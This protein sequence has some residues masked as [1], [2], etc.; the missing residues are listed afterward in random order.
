MSLDPALRNEL[1]KAVLRARGEAEDAA[2]AALGIL[3]VNSP[4]AFATLTK[5]QRVLRNALRAKSRQVGGFSMLVEEV[6]YAQWHRM[7]FARFLAE[8]NLLMHPEKHVAVTLDECEDLAAVE[9]DPDRWATAARYAGKMLPGIFSPDDPTVEVSFAPEGRAA[10]DAILAALPRPVFTSDDG[11]GWVYQFWQSKKKKEVSGSGRKIEKLDLAAYSQLFTEDYMVRFLLENSLGAWWAARHPD[12]KLL[13]DFKYLRSRDDGTPAAGTFPGWPERAADVTVMDPC[14]GSG[15]FLVAAFDMLR[16]MRMEEEGIGEAEAAAAVLRDNL[17]GLEIDPR[18]VQI[19]AFALALAAWKAGGYGD[20]PL[21]NVACSGIAARGQLEAWTRLARDDA[22]MRQALE[23]LHGMF[24]NAPDLGS[25]IDPASVPVRERMFAPDFER[26]GPLLERA[27]ARER[28]DDPVAAVFGNAALAVARA[29]QLLAGK[30]TLVATNVPYLARG[31]QGNSLKDFIELRHGEAKADLATA[32]V[33]RCR[34]LC[35]SGGAYAVVTP[36]NWLFLNSYRKFRERMLREQTWCV[37]ARLG[38]GAFESNAAAGAFVVL[39][40]FADDQIGHRSAWGGIDASSFATPSAKAA[41]LATSSLKFAPQTAQLRN[42]D[43][44]IVIGGLALTGSPL[45]TFAATYEGLHTGDYPR[46]GRYFWELPSIDGGWE[47]QQSASATHVPWG[48]RENVIFWEDESGE[49]V[50][51]VQERLGS[52]VTTRWIKGHGAWGQPGVAV[53]AMRD[54]RAT[55]YGGEVFTHGVFAVIPRDETLLPALFSFLQSEEF[56]KIARSLDQKLAI[57]RSVFDGIPFDQN[58]WRAVADQQYPYGLPEPHSDDPT[59]W[60]FEGDPSDSTAPLQVAVARLLAY[61]WPQQDADGLSHL[62]IPD[63]ILPLAPVA[64]HEPASERLRRVLKSSYGQWWSAESLAELLQQV[65]YADKG[66]SAW[67]RDGFFQQHCKLFH[68]PPLHLARLGRAQGRV[69]GPGE[70]PQA[71]LRQPEQAHLHV[72]RRV[73]P[74]PAGR[75][76]VRHA[77]RGRQAGGGPGVAG[78]ARGDTRRRA[79]LRRLRPVEAAARTTPRLGPRPQRRRSSQHQ[80]LR[81]GGRPPQPGEREMEQ[82]PGSQPRRLRARQRPSLHAGREAGSAGG[83]EGMTTAAVAQTFL[84][85]LVDALE[86]AGAYNRQ[87]QAPPAAVLWP[88]E[89][90]QWESLLP[91]L[92]ERLPV[93]ALGEYSPDERTGPAYWLRCVIARTIQHPDLPPGRAP[94]LYLPGYARQ[95][96]RALEDCPKEL[97]P[98]AELQY[99]GV[100]WNQ[101][102]GRDWT[103]SAFLQN[104]D[105]GLGIDVGADQG[106]R[107]ALKRALVKLANEPLAALHSEAPLRPFYLDGLLH[108]DYVKNVLSWLNAPRAYREQSTAE[109][110]SAFAALCQSRYDFHPDED[111]PVTAAEKLGQRDGRWGMVWSRFAESPATYGT[112]PDLLRQAKPE[113]TLP[114]AR[115]CRVVAPGQRDGG[116]RSARCPGPAVRPRSRCCPANRPR[117]GPG[118]RST[119]GTGYGPPWD[120]PPWPWQSSTLAELAKATDT[121]GVGNV[122]VGERGWLCQVRMGRRPRSSKRAGLRREAGRREGRPVGGA[123]H[124]P[125]V[126]GRCQQR[127]S[128]TVVAAGA[129]DYEAAPPP[130]VS[131][132]DVPPVRRRASIRP[133]SASSE[134]AGP[135]TR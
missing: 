78:E 31:K 113:M 118:P 110:W 16:R 3:A 57:A 56:R 92:R 61:Q 5:D 84:D 63:G 119:E 39:V 8:N 72:P 47:Y 117:P 46:F 2:R 106:T 100:L 129:D 109:E 103:I 85:A 123:Y 30:Y 68:Q 53:A 69:L 71:G 59:Q 21:P 7:L 44:R 97:K 27:L 114:H 45:S 4:K 58:H 1:E 108:P 101:K 94:V 9:G 115:S 132:R 24:V 79:A 77:G 6:A 22:N 122:V 43:A 66:L 28:A 121:H 89:G 134:A 124:I 15:H 130:E 112:I 65:G 33:E 54:L 17:F 67:L 133:R 11:L 107:E 34:F 90:R 98:L 50:E 49:L 131:Q 75:T 102:N 51:F 105:G 60:L 37:L 48:G 116:G 111:G 55:L 91:L 42:P 40:V 20:L 13:K 104:R 38:E 120:T 10:L 62:A 83:G 70:L 127:H 35:A 64:G 25:L 52:E 32:F 88:D 23:R 82:G 80:A 135:A 95:H 12:S 36:Q 26:V 86:R 99:R 96:V 74:R 87:D 126:A 18:C 76:G 14:C 128:R 81:G 19:A 125:P 41:G 73:G 29:A 93:F